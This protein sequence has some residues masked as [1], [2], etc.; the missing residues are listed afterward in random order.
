MFVFKLLYINNNI[1]IFFDDR[2]LRLAFTKS[3][4]DENT[5]SEGTDVAGIAK[6]FLAN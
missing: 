5:L 1:L 4:A 6:Y 2:Q 3:P